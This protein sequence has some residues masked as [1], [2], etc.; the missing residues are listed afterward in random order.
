MIKKPSLLCEDYSYGHS[1]H[2]IQAR[3]A[4]EEKMYPAQVRYLGSNLFKV[5]MKY[6]RS[7]ELY[8]HE[9][10]RLL[11]HLEEYSNGQITYSVRFHLLGIRTDGFGTSMFS[12]SDE[13]LKRCHVPESHKKTFGLREADLPQ[14]DSDGSLGSESGSTNG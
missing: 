6:G 9:P 10:S 5:I 1:P 14:G 4:W 13:P 2:F 12:M 8:N 7:L 3:K 11:E